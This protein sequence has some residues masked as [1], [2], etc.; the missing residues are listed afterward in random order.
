MH[1]SPL[2]LLTPKLQ[3]WNDNPPDSNHQFGGYDNTELNASAD[4][5]STL[6]YE[7]RPISN[8]LESKDKKPE[9]D[10]PAT[11]KSTKKKGRRED[12]FSGYISGK[13]ADKTNIII[14]K[15]KRPTRRLHSKDSTYCL[16]KLFQ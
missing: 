12:E 11:E 13:Y 2:R 9:E 7:L 15:M 8:W 6:E 16:E 14:D 3:E 10:A 4:Y 5:L 1:F